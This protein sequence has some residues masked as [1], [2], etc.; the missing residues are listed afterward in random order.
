MYHCGVFASL[1]DDTYRKPMLGCGKSLFGKWNGGIEVDSGESF[2]V[3]DAAGR[4]KYRDHQD[5][6][7]KW[8][9]NAGLGFYTPEEYFLAK[10]GV[11]DSFSA[12]ES[13][14]A[15]RSLVRP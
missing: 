2:F 4:K 14:C 7:L 13:F 8:A 3:G 9:L 15:R 5:T 11:R 12:M 6:D 10:Q 1:A